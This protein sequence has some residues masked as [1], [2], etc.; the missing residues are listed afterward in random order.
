MLSRVVKSI[1]IGSTALKQYSR[2]P[3]C[4]QIRQFSDIVDGKAA[5]DTS[6]SNT[7]T[8]SKLGS[9]AKAFEE[10]EKLNAQAEVAVP[11]DN[12]PFKKLFRESKFIDVSL[13]QMLLTEKC[14]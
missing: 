3:L 11:V 2:L 6:A 9:F 10:F 1:Q 4:T 12:I 14:I 8:N 7:E 5:G 13:L